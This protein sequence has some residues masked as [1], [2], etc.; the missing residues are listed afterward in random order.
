MRRRGMDRRKAHKGSRVP[1]GR[2]KVQP[3]GSVGME[4]PEND[5][6]RVVYDGDDPDVEASRKA[7]AEWD[8]KIKKMNPGD[9]HFQVW[10]RRLWK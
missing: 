6:E 3:G 9:P 5:S 1:Q 7:F 4:N 2:R 10:L 8:D